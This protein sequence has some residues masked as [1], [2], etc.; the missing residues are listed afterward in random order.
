MNPNQSIP[1]TVAQPRRWPWIVAIVVA[2]ALGGVI[3]GSA[4]KPAPVAAPTVT[5][6]A[7]GT[8]TVTTVVTT[9]VTP[10]PGPLTSISEGTY[11][12]GTGPGQVAPGTY[13]TTG[14]KVGAVV[15]NCY[16]ERLRNTSGDFTALIAND[17]VKGPTTLTIAATDGAFK[18]SGCQPW[19]IQK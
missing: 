19:A 11:V 9:T 6:T 18:T 5:T 12:V 10:P 3:F 16:W 15:P 1:V 2:F 4:G 8:T 13:A 14:A 17:N 7:A